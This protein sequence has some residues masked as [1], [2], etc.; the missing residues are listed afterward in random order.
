MSNTIYRL[1]SNNHRH[2]GCFS[3]TGRKFEC[4]VLTGVN[5]TRNSIRILYPMSNNVGK[6]IGKKGFSDEQRLRW[7]FSAVRR[8]DSI[9]SLS[10][11]AGVMEQTLNR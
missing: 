8:Q 11:E 3:G 4:Y 10:R 7:A 6:V 9:V 2:H 1:L 5:W